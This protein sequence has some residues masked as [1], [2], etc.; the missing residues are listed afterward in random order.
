[1]WD[2]LSIIDLNMA[3]R[4]V[5]KVYI[6]NDSPRDTLESTESTRINWYIV[7]YVFFVGMTVGIIYFTVHTYTFVG[8]PPRPPR[9]PKNNNKKRNL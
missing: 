9:P 7:E 5:K 8:L 2:S 3:K 6:P 1:M 4:V